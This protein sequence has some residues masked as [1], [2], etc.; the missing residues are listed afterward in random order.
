MGRKGSAYYK[1]SR[2]TAFH[3]Y[4]SIG[5]SKLGIQTVL[6]CGVLICWLPTL[7]LRTLVFLKGFL[8]FQKMR[9]DK[10]NKKPGLNYFF[11]VSHST[12]M[13][14]ARP[15][16][17]ARELYY[18]TSNTWATLATDHRGRKKTVHTT[19]KPTWEM[20][21][22][23]RWGANLKGSLH[24]VPPGHSWN[25]GQRA[26]QSW[27]LGFDTNTCWPTWVCYFKQ[28]TQHFWAPVSLSVKWGK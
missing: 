14:Q 25:Q 11:H 19:L 5:R 15:G 7:G 10:E 16:K 17:W 18:R 6:C 8:K 4:H 12:Y 24:L 27:Q 28:V 26:R 13:A 21:L 3:G 22:P 2:I 20:V 23:H 1:A 9:R